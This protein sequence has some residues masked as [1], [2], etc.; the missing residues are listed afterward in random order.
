VNPTPAL[1]CKNPLEEEKE[2]TTNSALPSELHWKERINCCHQNTN[3]TL[4][5]KLRTRQYLFFLYLPS[6]ACKLIQP[7]LL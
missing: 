3:H 6:S 5:K 4:A 7:N 1:T 2:E